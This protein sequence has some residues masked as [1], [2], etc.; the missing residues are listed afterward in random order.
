M[1]NEGNEHRGIIHPSAFEIVELYIYGY[2]LYNLVAGIW[3]QYHKYTRD[4]SSALTYFVIASMFVLVIIQNYLFLK[5]ADDKFIG[6]QRGFK[7]LDKN[8]GASRSFERIL[9]LLTIVF[10]I[11]APK[12]PIENGATSL[13][14]P[15]INMGSS[16]LIEIISACRRIV[17]N[18]F[19]WTAGYRIF[20]I[21]PLTEQEFSPLIRYYS[22]AIFIVVLLNLSWDLV[23]ISAVQRRKGDQGTEYLK[24]KNR[25]PYSSDLFSLLCYL[26]IARPV[27]KNGKD[28][29]EFT[30][31]ISRD[32]R[33]SGEFIEQRVK[34]GKLWTIYVLN[35]PIFR[36]RLI[37]IVFSILISAGSSYIFNPTIFVL[38]IGFCVAFYAFY[39]SKIDR[40]FYQ[41]ISP[42]T[43][44]Y[45]YLFS[46][47]D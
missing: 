10:V 32:Y 4:F 33:D 11:L 39:L 35:S 27:F 26:H 18:I 23:N 13:V 25:S 34:S 9:R 43:T 42:L 30:D 16:L 44:I 45:N 20:D 28:T 3:T 1:V 36:C 37:G 41:L 7:F 47:A 12:Y 17:D 15:V 22:G 46:R 8:K 24:Y 38:C 2:A 5:V 19:I 14:E 6:R 29:I 21:N 31:Y 40:V